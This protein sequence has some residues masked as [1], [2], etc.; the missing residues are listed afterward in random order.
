MAPVPA[1]VFAVL[2]I[3]IDVMYIMFTQPTYNRVVMRISGEPI[4]SGKAYAILGA[5]G[6]YIAMALGWLVLVVPTVSSLMARGMAKWVAGLVAGLAYGLVIYGVFN[7]SLYMMFK[8][9]DRS[10]VIQDMAWG[11]SWTTLITVLYASSR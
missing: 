7:A 4:Q 6:A 9:W 2:Y 11:L 8:K 1:Y 5:M 3:V 10:I